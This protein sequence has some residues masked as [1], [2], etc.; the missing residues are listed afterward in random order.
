MKLNK[1]SITYMASKGY[2]SLTILNNSMICEELQDYPDDWFC[3]LLDKTPVFEDQQGWLSLTRKGYESNKEEIKIAFLRRFDEASK[4]KE[5]ANFEEMVEL[6]F[7]LVRHN[8]QKMIKKLKNKID[9]L[10]NFVE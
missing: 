6:H 1:N 7:L 9:K 10:E 8:K 2:V 5:W 4:D 3:E